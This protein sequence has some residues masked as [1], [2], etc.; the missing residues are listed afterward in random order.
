MEAS[1]KQPDGASVAVFAYNE[2]RRIT[3]ALQSIDREAEGFSAPVEVHILANGCRDG[4]AA[5]ARQFQPRRVEV[6]VHEIKLGDKAN[7]W[8]TYV[9][10]IAPA[11]PLHFFMDGDVRVHPGSLA[12]M[13]EASR[14]QPQAH[15]VSS[16][17]KSGRTRHGWAAFIRRNHGLPGCLYL[18]PERTLRRFRDA[19][20]RLP[21]GLIGEDVLL[22][23]LIKRDLGEQLDGERTERI[24]VCEAAGFE[25]DSLSPRSLA[26]VGLYYRRLRRNSLRELQ[27]QVLFPLLKKQGAAALPEHA[28]QL[29]TPEA[30]SRLRPRRGVVQAY[31]DRVALRLMRRRAARPGGAGND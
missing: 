19:A 16:L 29:Y 17:P 31:F 25:N 27:N 1:S 28:E 14:Q 13:A 6:T 24:H 23:F 21:V 4:T 9:H 3:D 22:Q 11:R 8:N 30:L 7:A 2:E 12:A 5:K 26:D 18:L 20:I 15:A 10:D